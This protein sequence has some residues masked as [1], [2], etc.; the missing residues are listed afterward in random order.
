MLIWCEGS[1]FQAVES[2]AFLEEYNLSAY[3]LDYEGTNVL[4]WFLGQ[5]KKRYPEIDGNLERSQV[6]ASIGCWL[7]NNWHFL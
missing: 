2:K 3:V 7:G 6:V 4:H 1:L 5:T